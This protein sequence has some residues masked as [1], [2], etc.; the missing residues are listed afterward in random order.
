LTSRSGVVLYFLGR[1]F[2]SDGIKVVGGGGCPRVARGKGTGPKKKEKK[3]E[4]VGEMDLRQLASYQG[5][6]IIQQFQLRLANGRA[7]TFNGMLVPN[8]RSGFKKG[9]HHMGGGSESEEAGG[10]KLSVPAHLK[11]GQPRKG[12]PEETVP[13]KTSRRRGRSKPPRL[14]HSTL[15]QPSLSKVHCRRG[16]TQ[17]GSWS[18]LEIS[19]KKSSN[20]VGVEGTPTKVGKRPMNR[21]VV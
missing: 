4:G 11:Q 20:V 17:A 13:Q 21:Q 16:G 8:R 3:E 15:S 10:K 9:K 2:I 18:C 5:S 12:P 6:E 7:T 1:R 14:L 19:G